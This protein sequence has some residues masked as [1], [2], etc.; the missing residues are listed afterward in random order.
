VQRKRHIV[1][2]ATALVMVLTA[3]GGGSSSDNGTSVD[4]DA[5]AL[6]DAGT[7][8]KALY[9]AKCTTCHRSDLSGGTGPSLAPGSAAFGKP[10]SELRA[11]IV[12][13]G[14]GMP[15]WGGLLSDVEIDALVTFLAEAQGR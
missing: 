5:I 12:D 6:S 15:S 8:G 2:L 4:V 3:C 14:E 13:G 1:V 11:K 9:T 10:T 7:A